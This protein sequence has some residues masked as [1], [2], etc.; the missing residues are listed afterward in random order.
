MIPTSKNTC[1]QYPCDDMMPGDLRIAWRNGFA[2]RDATALW[3][4]VAEILAP[5]GLLRIDAGVKERADGE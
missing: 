2:V 3:Q 1:R 5:A 4:Q